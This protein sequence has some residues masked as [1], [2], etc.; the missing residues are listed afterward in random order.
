MSIGNVLKLIRFYSLVHFNT[1][2]P[3]SPFSV[4]QMSSTM[5]T[6]ENTS[7]LTYFYKEIVRFLS[8][9]SRMKMYG[10]E[11]FESRT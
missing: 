4:A 3:L 5:E 2:I 10:T 8:S 11:Y 9:T 7:V 1:G 6:R